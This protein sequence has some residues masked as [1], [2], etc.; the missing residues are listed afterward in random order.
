MPPDWEEL[1]KQLPSSMLPKEDQDP[2]A[3]SRVAQQAAEAN[4]EHDDVLSSLPDLKAQVPAPMFGE[5]HI[6]TGLPQ[7]KQTEPQISGTPPL[8]ASQNLQELPNQIN[9]LREVLVELKT[10]M[11]N[12]AQQIINKLDELLEMP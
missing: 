12:Q 7:L 3:P 4:V 8:Q 2:L 1:T 10:A 5:Q 9:S 11:V 6:G